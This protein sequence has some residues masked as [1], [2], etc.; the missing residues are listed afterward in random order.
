MYHD[1]CLR[2]DFSKQVRGGGKIWP[3]NISNDKFHS[4]RIQYRIDMAR[5]R[6]FLSTVLWILTGRE[7]EPS[8]LA[9]ARLG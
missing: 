1:G 6:L 9:A 8:S 4:A 5:Q 3:Q 7:H 2:G